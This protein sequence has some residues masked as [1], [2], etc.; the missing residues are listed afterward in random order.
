MI[1]YCR[2]KHDAIVIPVSDYEEAVFFEGEVCPMCGLVEK[3]AAVQE[4]LIA[5]EAALEDAQNR[6]ADVLE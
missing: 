5:T 6:L 3:L 4:D 2:K 1:N